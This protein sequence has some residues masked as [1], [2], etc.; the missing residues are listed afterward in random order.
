MDRFEQYAAFIEA[1]LPV[2]IETAAIEPDWVLST[3]LFG[4]EPIYR[5]LRRE[6]LPCCRFGTEMISTSCCLYIHAKGRC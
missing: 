1:M 3:Y 4:S 2:A 6:A 5:C